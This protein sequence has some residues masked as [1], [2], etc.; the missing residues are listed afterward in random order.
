MGD[1]VRYG[2]QRLRQHDTAWVG[3]LV[4]L[5]A[6][7]M[8]FAALCFTFA[9]LR[10]RAAQWPPEG[11]GELPRSLAAWAS[12]LLLASSGSYELARTALFSPRRW[13]FRGWLLATWTLGAAFLA[14]MVMLWVRAYR[15]GIQLGQ[16]GH[17]AA[18]FWAMTGFH[19]LHALVGLGAIGWLVARAV[20]GSL[21]P[22]RALPLRLW[23]V[24]WHFVVAAW[25]VVYVEVFVW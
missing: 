14:L 11:S 16:P 4:F 8:T 24:Y 10:V 23:A 13:A 3:T 1:L 5:V 19:A 22:A 17:F 9:Y 21:T 25:L 12:A 20:L 6:W 15:S 7:G 18:G 2:P